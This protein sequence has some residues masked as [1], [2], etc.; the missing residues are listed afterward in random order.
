MNANTVSVHVK[1][2]FTA[3]PE[4]VFSAWLDPQMIGKWMFGPDLRD[5][6]VV[7]LSLDARVGGSFSFV[8]RR[9]GENVD[10][11]GKYIEIDQPG[12]L[13]FSWGI[14]GVSGDESRVVIDIV[15][16]ASGCELSLIHEMHAEWED[17][18]ER[19]EAGWSLMLDVLGNNLQQH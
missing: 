15:P 6:E 2:C 18:A 14:A 17:Y 8:V 7:S 5:E 1:H 11:I 16:L 3:P 4:Q 10:H 19:V 9:Q 13:V 12:R